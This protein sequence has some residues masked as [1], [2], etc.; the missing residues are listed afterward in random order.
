M[1]IGPLDWA[2]KNVSQIV[3]KVVTEAEEDDII[4]LHDCYK[5]SVEA[6]IQ[7]VDELQER[8]FIL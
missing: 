8:G 4:L 3:N 7:I 5:S 1:S 2:P 6:A